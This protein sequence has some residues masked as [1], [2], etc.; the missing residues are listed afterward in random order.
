MLTKEEIT[1]YFSDLIFNENIHKYSKNN[2]D[3]ISV[4]KLIEQYYTAFDKTIAKRI[5]KRKNC[6]EQEILN[7]WDEISRQASKRGHKA[8]DFGEAYMYNHSLQPTT[9][10]EKAI[11]TFWNKVPDY[12]IPVGAEIKM[13]HKKFNYAGTA[14]IILYNKNTNS[15]IIGDYKTNRD[16]F[17]NFKGQKMLGSFSDKLDTPFNHYQIQLS[18]YQILFEQ[19]GVTVSNRFILWL[20]DDGTFQFRKTEDFTKILLNDLTK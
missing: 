5:A 17:K 20:L 8:H 3:L 7:K 18:Y 19:L 9:P 6:S 15:Y 4:S 10:L 1:N 16:L 13:Y 14:D 12:V 11:Q 2:K